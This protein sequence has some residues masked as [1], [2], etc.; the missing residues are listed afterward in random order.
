MGN[1]KRCEV[2]SDQEDKREDFVRSGHVALEKRGR[3]E[4]NVERRDSPKRNVV[5]FIN[6]AWE[7]KRVQFRLFLFLASK[8]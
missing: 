8:M 7:E 3:L 1:K 5:C 6:S 2:F 4:L